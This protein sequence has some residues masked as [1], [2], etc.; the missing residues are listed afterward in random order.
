MR[1]QFVHDGMT[2]AKMPNDSDNDN[3]GLHAGFTLCYAYRILLCHF[4]HPGQ[5]SNV[6]CVYRYEQ[7]MDRKTKHLFVNATRTPFRSFVSDFAPQPPYFS[8]LRQALKM[9]TRL[10]TC[11]WIQLLLCYS[12]TTA[13]SDIHVK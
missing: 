13:E 5:Y 1:E 8:P 10:A 6:A 2:A 3:R 11:L 7:V 4:F 9:Q 12:L